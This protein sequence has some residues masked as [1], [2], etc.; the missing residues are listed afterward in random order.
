MRVFTQNEPE[1]D[2]E[3]DRLGDFLKDCKGGRAK[4][5]SRGST[6]SSPPSSSGPKTVMPSEYYPEVFGGEMSDTCEFGSLDEANEMARGRSTRDAA[7]G[8]R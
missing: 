5:P 3:S 8:R 4:N 7:A 2:A 1:T 6:G